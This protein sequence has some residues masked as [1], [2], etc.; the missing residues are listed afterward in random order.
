MIAALISS[1]KIFYPVVD[2]ENGEVVTGTFFT[3]TRYEGTVADLR[4]GDWTATTGHATGGLVGTGPFDS[5][6]GAGLPCAAHK[7]PPDGGRERG[8]GDTPL[9]VLMNRNTASAAE[10]FAA[11]L[12]DNGAATLVGER[13][14]G[15]GCGYVDGGNGLTLKHSGVKVRMPNCARYRADGSNEVEGIVPDVELPWTGED[16]TRFE[17]YAEKALKHARELF[18]PSAH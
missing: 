5:T 10:F 1:G 8:L 6:Y 14:I 16:L 13:T 9:Y 12:S 17:S 18:T 2:D 11:V 4:C 3:G 7:P 15:A